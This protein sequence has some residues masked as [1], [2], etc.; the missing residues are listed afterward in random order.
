MSTITAQRPHTMPKE[1]AKKKAEELASHLAQ[2]LGIEW[3]WKGDVL[4][5]EAPSGTAKGTKGEVTVTDTE[6]AVAVQLPFLLKMM[7]PMI[8]SKVKEQ[9]DTIVA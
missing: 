5:F 8:E 9:L 2:R 1:K 4:Y 6:I 3:Q 7:S